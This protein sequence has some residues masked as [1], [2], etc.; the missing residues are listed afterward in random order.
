MGA[1]MVLRVHSRHSQTVRTPHPTSTQRDTI[2]HGVACVLWGDRR[3]G[4]DPHSPGM[5]RALG[6]LQNSQDFSEAFTCKESDPIN[7]PEA[8]LQ[9]RCR[10]W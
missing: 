3:V 10:V 8:G 5:F 7:T 9:H 4:T 6:V 2:H 1:D